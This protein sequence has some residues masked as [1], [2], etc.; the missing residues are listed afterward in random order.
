MPRERRLFIGIASCLH[1]TL[2]RNTSTLLKLTSLRVSNKLEHRDELWQRCYDDLMASAQRRL[3]Q[4]VVR[5]GG[6]YAHV[7]DE[8]V[9]SRRDDRTRETWLHG[10]FTYMLYGKRQSDA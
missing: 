7:L 1:L 9:D 8:V 6:H 4:E 3:E 2:K 5:L 10:V